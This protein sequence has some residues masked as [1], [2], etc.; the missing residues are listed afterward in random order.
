MTLILT[1]TPEK[2]TRLTAQAHRVGLSLDEY[3]QRMLDQAAETPAPDLTAESPTPNLT[4]EER[5]A[6]FEA[7]ADSHGTDTPLL[8][9]EAISRAAIYSRD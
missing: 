6:R 1:L 8:S 5:I 2:Q 4:P 7:W 9:D 3:V